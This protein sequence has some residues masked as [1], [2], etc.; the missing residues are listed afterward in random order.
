MKIL[1][2][3]PDLLNLY[4]EYGNVAVLSKCLEAIGAEP[5]IYHAELGMEFDVNDYDMIY[6]G[7]GTESASMKALEELRPHRKEF[8]LFI[9][10]GKLMILTGNSFELFGQYINDDKLGQ[11]EGLKIFSYGVNRTHKKRFLSD[12]IFTSMETDKKVIGFINKCS[13]I[14]GVSSPLF[15]VEYGLGNDNLP[16]TEGFTYKNVLAT[17]LIGPLLVRNPYLLEYIVGLIANAAGLEM[18]ALPLENEKK[19]YEI[20]LRELEAL[21]NK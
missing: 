21:E 3:Y 4:G 18:C 1:Y 16:S 13:T 19:A 5:E 12:A 15:N 9:E 6:M 11:T 20:A 2:I 14:V 17:N 8:E 10:S 7:C